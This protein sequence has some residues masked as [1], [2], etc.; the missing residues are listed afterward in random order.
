[1]DGGVRAVEQLRQVMATLKI[2]DVGAQVALSMHVDFAN[3]SDFAP[4]DHQKEALTTLLDEVVAWS[5]ALRTLRPAAYA[6]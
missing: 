6:A 2:A 4:R 3:F 1:M 5:T